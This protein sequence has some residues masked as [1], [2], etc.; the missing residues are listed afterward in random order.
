M[1]ACDIGHAAAAA[2]AAAL[3]GL[4]DLLLPCTSAAVSSGNE[5]GS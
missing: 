3:G 1:A 2:A 5:P 4:T